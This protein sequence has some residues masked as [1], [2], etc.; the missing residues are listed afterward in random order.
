MQYNTSG[1]PVEQ[2]YSSVLGTLICIY[3]VMLV[4]LAVS[5]WKLFEKADYAGWKCLI[6]FYNI[7]IIFEAT[8]GNGWLFLLLFIPLVNY[9]MYIYLAYKTALAFDKGIGYTLGFIFLPFV[10]IPV[11]AFGNAE[12]IGPQ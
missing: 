5:V 9:I 1:Y 2:M 6:P 12:Y 8:C 4:V 10:F 11:L 3:L 7:Y